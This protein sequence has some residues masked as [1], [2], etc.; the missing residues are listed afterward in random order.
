[1]T[2]VA[3]ILAL[4]AIALVVAVRPSTAIARLHSLE[5]G[6]DGTHARGHWVAARVRGGVGLLTVS[7]GAVLGATA[8]FGFGAPIPVLPVLAGMVAG[9][10]AG[11]LV[12]GS[13]AARER[14]RRDA[15]LVESVGALAADLRAG[16]QPADV[17]AADRQP[18]H[19]RSAAVA[20]VW[21]VSERSGAPAAAVLDR[22]EQDLRARERQ[23]REVAAQLAGAR[24]TAA[25]LAVLPL[26]GIGLGA[27]MGARPLHV[28]LGTGRGQ[29]ALL[30]GAGLDALGLLWTARIVKSA[31]G[32]T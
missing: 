10:A 15:E 3:W 20:A 27:A 30:V 31:G 32:E 28:L 8:H 26:L 9:G 19:L 23:H 7:G 16:R 22:V 5:V 11:V 13:T 24:S 6:V 1:M 18:P 4:L 12:A 21:A 2:D 25:L 29:V 14:R 17:M